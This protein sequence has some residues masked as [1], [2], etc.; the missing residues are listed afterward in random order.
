MELDQVH[1]AHGETGP[2]DEASD[3]AVERHVAE[4]ELLGPK[5]SR[6]LFGGIEHLRN[7]LLARER[8]V[9]EVEL[10]VDG[11]EPPFRGRGRHQ[12]V[13]LGQAG[14]G[15]EKEPGQ[16]EHDV[17]HLPDLP[18]G[19][20]E[21]E[22]EGPGLVGLGSQERMKALL[23]DRLGA[24]LG[25]RLDLHPALRRRDHRVALRRP[26]DGDGQV[27]LLGDVDRPRHEQPL[28]LQTF[29]R[30]LRRDH[31]MRE[32]ELGRLPHLLH[33]A[34]QPHEPRLA[35]AARVDLG[36]DHHL[37]I[38]GAEEP[39]RLRGGFLHRLHHRTRRGGNAGV[40]QKLA[41]LVFVDFHG[42][43]GVRSQESAER[44]TGIRDRTG[45]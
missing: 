27:V 17:R 22:G 21:L 4:P 23:V 12:G 32:H 43:A 40:G 31:A 2:V 1:G 45:A 37:R 15:L 8:V 10:G 41:G 38:L 13:D 3:V 35:S 26:I 36:L 18:A 19:E 16:L 28:D 9:V 34:D 11:H 14:V 33:G 42:G 24:V 39:L 44:G 29:R 6:V 25:D 5:L 20:T 30:C 7:T